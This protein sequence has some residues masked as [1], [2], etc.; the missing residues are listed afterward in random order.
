MLDAFTLKFAVGWLCASPVFIFSAAS[1]S[2]AEKVV[3]YGGALTAAVV[4]WHKVIRPLV[5]GLASIND[6]YRAA[7]IAEVQIA[8]IQK[9][10]AELK[11]VWN[12]K[13]S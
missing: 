4:V 5:A 9:D 11:E 12:A 7:L 13:N 3:L 1:E 8:E 6:A 2:V 10:I